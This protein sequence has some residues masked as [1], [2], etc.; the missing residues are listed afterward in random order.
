MTKE[1]KDKDFT[2]ALSII[3]GELKNNLTALPE[4]LKMQTA[5]IRLRTGK[6]VVLFGTYGSAFLS[7]GQGI[8]KEREKSF[9]CYSRDMNDIF[10][11]LCSFSVHTH[12]QSIVNGFITIQGGHRVGICGTAVTDSGNGITSVRDISSLNIRIAREK[13]GCSDVIYNTLFHSGLQSIIIAGSPMTGKTTVLRDLVRRISD[14]EISRKVCVIDERQEIAAMNAGFC[15]RDVG[16]NT[17]VFDLYPKDKAV[18][19][20]VKTMSPELIAMDELCS[21][22]EIEAVRLGVNSGVKFIVTV[23]AADYSEILSREQIKKLLRTYSFEKLVLLKKDSLGQVE[24]I[25]DTKELLD[26]II[27]RDIGLGKYDIY[28]SDDVITA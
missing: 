11:R 15:Q 6:P 20:A 1:I 27:G 23:H 17:D 18:I 21:D 12:L 26:E 4:E 5:E 13:R 16:L 9:V 24:G 8:T 19:N 10:S 25:Y 2:S 3:R 28:G 22:S 14:G 7:A